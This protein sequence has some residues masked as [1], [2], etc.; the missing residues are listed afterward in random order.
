MI[1]IGHC[2]EGRVRPEN[3]GTAEG[4]CCGEHGGMERTLM[5]HTGTATGTLGQARELQAQCLGL[6]VQLDKGLH[7]EQQTTQQ[8]EWCFGWERNLCSQNSRGSFV[9]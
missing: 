2:R 3:L 9:R 8:A 4:L 6:H 1:A 5:E 7:R